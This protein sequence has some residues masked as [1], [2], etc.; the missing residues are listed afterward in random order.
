M[1]RRVPAN[2]RQHIAYTLRD[3]YWTA[4][5]MPPGLK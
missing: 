3:R 2:T 4:G 1:T 5:A